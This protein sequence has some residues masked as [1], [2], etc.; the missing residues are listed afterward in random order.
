MP[1]YKITIEYDGQDFHGWQRQNKLKTIQGE[2]ETALYKFCGE[3]IKVFGAGR[4]DTGVHALAEVAHLEVDKNKL[5]DKTATEIGKSFTYFTHLIQL[6]LSLEFNL[7][8]N[9]G[10]E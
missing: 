3:K 1:R 8:T 7:I 10:V 9:N 4:T 6:D 2:L 5:E